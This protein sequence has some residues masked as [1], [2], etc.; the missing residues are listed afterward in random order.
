VEAAERGEEVI[1]ARSGVPV[2]RLTACSP[3]RKQI[4]FGALKGKIWIA[5][6][7]GAP[8]PDDLLAEF[9]KDL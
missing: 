9:E 4:R 8:L 6:D 1:L 5:D 3:A 2:A 7:F